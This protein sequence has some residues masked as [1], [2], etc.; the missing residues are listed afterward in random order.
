VAQALIKANKRFDY[1]VF[2]GQRHGYGDMREYFFW[3]M[4]D[5]FAEHLLGDSDNSTDI[6]H[7][8]NE[9]AMNH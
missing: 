2:P 6:K 9:R 5:Y 4:A 3:L 1:F 8:N 7:M